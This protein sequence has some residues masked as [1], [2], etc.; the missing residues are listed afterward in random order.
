MH[1]II[2]DDHHPHGHQIADVLRQQVP[3]V[4]VLL[5]GNSEASIRFLRDPS[6]A[7]DFILI[8]INVS[9]GDGHE[10]LLKIK[11]MKHLHAVPVIMYSR[12]SD[13]ERLTI[14]RK[15]GAHD[16]IPKK[17]ANFDE[18]AQEIIASMSRKSKPAE[19]SSFNNI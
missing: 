11:A 15:L 17:T 12:L 6:F 8:E 14:F 18:H 9:G 1:V 5:T 7:P 16:F 4:E 10:C 19:A 3:G 13:H 2:I